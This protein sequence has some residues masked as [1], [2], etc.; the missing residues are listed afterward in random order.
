[1]VIERFDA[2]EWSEAKLESLVAKGD[3]P[4][5]TG[6]GVPIQWSGS[7][8]DLP[9]GY[10]ATTGRLSIFARRPGHLTLS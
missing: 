5:A 1:L 3:V 4:V 7:V 10:T 2:R 6:W 8:D 9:S